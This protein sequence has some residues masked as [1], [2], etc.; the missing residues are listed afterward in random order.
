MIKNKTQNTTITKNH[1]ECTDPLSQTIGLMFSS[2]PT[3]LIFTFKKEKNVPLHMWFVF[4]P[5]DVL[6]L[7]KNKEVIHLTEN[8][9]PFT[10]Y[11]PKV[12]SMYVIE[13]PIKSIKESKTKIGDKIEF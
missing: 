6:W 13:L 1:K 8:F 7:N 5:I 10:I 11:D 2:K 4:Y 3:P 9:K 12:K